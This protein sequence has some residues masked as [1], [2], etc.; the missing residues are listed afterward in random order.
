VPGSPWTR[1]A[2][3]DDRVDRSRGPGCR[4][5]R[6][7]AV[8][9]LRAVLL[10]AVT[11]ILC[12]PASAQPAALTSISLRPG[13]GGAELT[14]ALS[15]WAAFTD[16][17]LEDPARVVLDIE[18][19]RHL[20]AQSRYVV[21]RGG[22]AAVHA[23]QLAPDVVRIVVELERNSPYETSRV[24]EGILLRLRAHTGSF[25]DWSTASPEASG[26]TRLSSQPARRADDRT[27]PPEQ[28]RISVAFHEVDIRDV[29]ASFAEISGRSIVAGAGVTGNVTA[30]IR[31]QPW[32]V[33]MQ[34]ILR[35]HGLGAQELP[36]GIIQIH[37][38]DTIQAR[39]IQE[40]LV[41]QAIRVTYLPVLEVVASLQPLLSERGRISTVPST[42][43]L[44]VTDVEGV[45]QAVRGILAQLD[46]RTQQVAIQAKIIFVN[47]TDVEELGVTYDL[48]DSRGSSLG[49]RAPDPGP[50]SADGFTT[51]SSVGLRGTAIAALGNANIR[52]QQPQL[53][54]V[55]SLVLGRHSLTAFIDALQVQEMLD[56]QA[57]PLI[58]T[59]DNHEAEIWVGERTPIRVVDLGT[60]GVNGAGAAMPRA[61]AE[62]VETGVRLRV[63]P[64]ITADRRI[65]MQL[66]AERS[67]AQ[68]AATDV[69]VIFLTQLG[70]TRLMVEDG[71]TAVIAGLTVTEVGTTRAGIPLLMKIPV[72]GGLFRTSRTRELKRD[73]LIMVTPRIIESRP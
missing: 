2:A 16:W 48:Q 39:Q 55:L 21:D 45:V 4:A 64:H 37:A 58:T 42:N 10:A 15:G 50:A 27:R 24:P 44:I 72:V 67:S 29:I 19:A 32:D 46:V 6:S 17:G 70:T 68:L 57:A 20:L 62:L 26:T 23:I 63:T 30:T 61:S 36:S 1:R 51:A 8:R 3:A 22:V 5:R 11:T 71:E 31:D 66:H 34:T 13:T 18:G 35:A 14:I 54:A 33:A 53:E 73:L 47:R 52:I 56:V 41:T 65:L 60:A 7:A 25:D 59:L 38:V 43:T 9:L 69:G 40:P 12:A 28:S 49:R